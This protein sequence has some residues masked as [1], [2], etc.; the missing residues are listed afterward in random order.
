M[1]L[2]PIAIYWYFNNTMW[3]AALPCSLAALRTHIV[4]S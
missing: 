3:L 1:M 2:E 4:S